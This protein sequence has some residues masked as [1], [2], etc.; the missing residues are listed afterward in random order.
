MAT[1]HA[2]CSKAM[3]QPLGSGVKAQKST[4]LSDAIMVCSKASTLPCDAQRRRGMYQL[5]AKPDSAELDSLN[6]RE[7]EAFM[8]GKKLI[9]IVS[10]AASTGISLH[11][12]KQVCMCTAA[13]KCMWRPECTMLS[14][15]HLQGLQAPLIGLPL[16][17]VANFMPRKRPVVCSSVQTSGG[18]YT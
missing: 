13:Y 7:T 10:D 9:A 1:T 18:G 16:E 14:H 8:K 2:T 6:V 3:C 12:S 4:L 17:G 5:R 11:A 15:E